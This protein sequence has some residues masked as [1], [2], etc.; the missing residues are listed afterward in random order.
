MA[1]VTERII[2]LPTSRWNVLVDNYC[3]A[4]SREAARSST[5]NDDCLARIYLGRRCGANTPLSP[6]FYLRNFNFCLD[7]MLD[8]GFPIRE[9]AAEVA[10]CLA[11][12]HWGAIIDAYDIEFLLGRE[13]AQKAPYTTQV[14]ERLRM[15]VEVLEGMEKH[16]D[17]EATVER[18][19]TASTRLWVIDFNL[20]SQFLRDAG[21]ILEHQAES[22]RHLAIWYLP[23]SRMTPTIRCL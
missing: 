11:V 10:K 4:A 18:A 6:N 12:V 5:L 17:V 9:Y 19:Q 21:S 3:P 16:A 1:I 8:L 7:Q 15:D 20:C 13:E 23:S 22:I 14:T 2:P